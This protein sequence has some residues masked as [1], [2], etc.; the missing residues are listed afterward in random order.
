[1]IALRISRPTF[2]SNPACSLPSFDDIREKCALLLGNDFADHCAAYLYL[3]RCQPVQRV[4][5]RLHSRELNLFDLAALLAPESTRAF[6]QQALEV[7][8]EELAAARHTV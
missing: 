4:L 6:A 8:E 7:L 2:S 3:R 5:K 1:M